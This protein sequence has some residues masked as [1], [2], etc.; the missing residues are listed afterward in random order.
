MKCG[1]GEGWTKSVGRTRRHEEI[2]THGP[3]R[4]KYFKCSLIS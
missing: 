3:R 2:F 4:Q 1:S